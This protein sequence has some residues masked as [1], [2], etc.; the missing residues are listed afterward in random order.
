LVPNLQHCKGPLALRQR[1]GCGGNAASDTA[2]V[3]LIR[4]KKRDTASAA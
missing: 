3:G 1:L 2:A 4:E